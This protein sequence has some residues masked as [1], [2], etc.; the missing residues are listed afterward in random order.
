M[1]TT[2]KKIACLLLPP[3]L[4]LAG[5]AHAAAGHLGN[6]ETLG[7]KTGMTHEQVRAALAKINKPWKESQPRATGYYFDQA[8]GQ[9]FEAQFTATDSSG[10][11]NI[12]LTYSKENLLFKIKR[13]TQ[14]NAGARP[15]LATAIQSLYDKFGK[16]TSQ[17]VYSEMEQLFY[18]TL[19]GGK[20]ITAEDLPNK[21]GYESDAT[22]CFEFDKAP[23]SQFNNP[24]NLV[25]QDVLYAKC[26]GSVQVILTP[27]NPNYPNRS[28]REI[29]RSMDLEINDPRVFLDAAQKELFA[30][31]NK[32]QDD[33]NKAKNSGIK[34]TL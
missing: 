1:T 28:P 29:A 12:T 5:A 15:A 6:V 25:K 16:P 18:Y 33:I 19:D 8:I 21:R 26:G 4:L 32:L 3:A 34:P 2:V 31:Q 17:R 13:T 22:K 11:E 24:G 20:I 14:W 30:R 9:V 27:D 7:I 23:P 10:S